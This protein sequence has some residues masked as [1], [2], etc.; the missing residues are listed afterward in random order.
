VSIGVNNSLAI[1]RP[2]SGLPSGLSQSARRAAEHLHFPEQAVGI[3]WWQALARASE[4][5]ASPRL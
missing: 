2:G 5:D 3:R 4:M 1:G